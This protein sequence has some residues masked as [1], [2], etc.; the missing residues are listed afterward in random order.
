MRCDNTEAMAL[1]TGV[2]ST[3]EAHADALP[4]AAIMADV[5]ERVVDRNVV[6]EAPPGAGKTTVIPAT[7]VERGV[8]GDGAILVLGRD[9]LTPNPRVTTPFDFYERRNCVL[10]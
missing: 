5:V 8:L 3:L 2:A 9:N 4:I 10:I 1:Q 7:L 6:I